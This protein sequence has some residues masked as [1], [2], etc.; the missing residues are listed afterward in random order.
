MLEAGIPFKVKLR[1]AMHTNYMASITLPNEVAE[2]ERAME[3]WLHV[4]IAAAYDA[5]QVDPSRA[6]TVVS[7]RARLAAEHKKATD[8][9]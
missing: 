1:T 6:V 2:T 3:N 4:D 8:R 9:P 5:L 7:V